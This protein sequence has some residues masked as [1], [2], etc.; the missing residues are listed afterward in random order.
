[1]LTTTPED[2]NERGCQKTWIWLDVMECYFSKSDRSELAW[3]DCVDV[4]VGCYGVD[5]DDDDDVVGVRMSHWLPILPHHYS[6]Y[7]H[8]DHSS[9][10]SWTAHDDENCC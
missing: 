6:R 1:M 9:H 8:F 4:G 7:C 3:G 2:G 5:D 10:G